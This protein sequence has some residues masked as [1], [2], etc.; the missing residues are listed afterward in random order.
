M[1]KNLNPFKKKDEITAD[2]QDVVSDIQASSTAA[3]S[4]TVAASANTEPAEEKKGFVGKMKD[5]A[6]EK[7][8][9]KQLKDVPPAQREMLMSAIKKNPDFFET[10]AKKIKAEEERN[11]GNQMAAAM[12][13]MRENQ[14]DL[15]K[16]MQQ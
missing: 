7:M 13:V 9:E 10:L 8:L 12:K 3:N 5:K 16:I 2:A 14:G 4:T 15:M 6:V 1:F 11:G